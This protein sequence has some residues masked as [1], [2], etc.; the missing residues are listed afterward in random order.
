MISSLISSNKLSRSEYLKL[1]GLTIL[2]LSSKFQERISFKISEFSLNLG[3]TPANASLNPEDYRTIE[4][5]ILRA[6]QF[7]IESDNSLF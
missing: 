7:K 4:F 6:L 3:I 2:C 1:V 5:E